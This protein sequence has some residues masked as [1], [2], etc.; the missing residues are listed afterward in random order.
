[1]LPDIV[2]V[3]GKILDKIPLPLDMHFAFS[4]MSVRRRQVL[5]QHFPFHAISTSPMATA[6]GL[7]GAAKKEPAAIWNARQ[8]RVVPDTGTG[9]VVR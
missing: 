2:A 5:Y 8:G 3:T 4:D 7:C 6:G 1:M 9:T